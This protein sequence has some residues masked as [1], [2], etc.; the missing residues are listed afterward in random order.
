MK[1]PASI[2]AVLLTYFG[3]IIGVGFAKIDS[4]KQDDKLAIQGAGMQAQT[5][6]LRKTA[7]Q[8]A[9]AVKGN[10]VV[11]AVLLEAR[12]DRPQT[13]ELFSSIRARDPVLFD[14]LIARAER[15]DIKLARVAGDLACDVP[16]PSGVPSRPQTKTP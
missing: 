6:K 3:I 13:V 8:L 9:E 11:V 4:I 12:A 14:K 5:D 1:R 15:G 2:G 16:L 7:D 10:C